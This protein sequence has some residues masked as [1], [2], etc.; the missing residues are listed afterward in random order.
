MA[1]LETIARS[2]GHALGRAWRFVQDA[3]LAAPGGGSAGVADR[4]NAPA[5][6][7]ADSSPA[8]DPTSDG[9]RAR[10]YARAHFRLALLAMGVDLAALAIFLFS[11]ASVALAD[12][13]RAGWRGAAG[14][15]AP[16]PWR[17]VLVYSVLTGLGLKLLGLPFAL[18]SR[19]VEIR[20]GLNRQSRAAWWWDEGKGLALGGVLGLA[21]VELIYWLLRAA[22]RLWWLWAW[23]GFALFAVALAQLAPILLL[24]LF[25]KFRPLE[26]NADVDPREAELRRRLEALCARAGARVRGVYEW[27]LGAKSAKANAALVGW[28]ATRRII[29]SDTLLADSPAEEIEAVLAHELG[30]HARAHIWRGLAFQAALSLFGFWLADRCLAAL[31][32]PL[33]LQGAA[34]IAGLPLLVLVAAVLSLLLLPAANAFTRQMEREADDYAFAAGVGGVAGAGPLLAALERLAARNLA[35]VRPPAWKERIFYSH[36]AIATRLRRG[37]AWEAAHSPRRQS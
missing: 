8:S 6:G 28:G 29:V 26:D 37:R 22:P 18:R 36:P 2:F 13:L 7:G 12:R 10:A 14:A 5:G 21:G 17:L 15:A 24:P 20:Y 25:Y 33:H 23:A 11:G 27:K 32:A 35:E 1:A 34:D 3:S 9:A 16:G 4:Q 30:H 31:A 19:G